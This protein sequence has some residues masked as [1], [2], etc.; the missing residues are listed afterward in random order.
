MRQRLQVRRAAIAGY[1]GMSPDGIRRAD[2]IFAHLWQ[3]IEKLF[4]EQRHPAAR[5]RSGSR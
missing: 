5:K 3:S 4:P 1:D 2:V